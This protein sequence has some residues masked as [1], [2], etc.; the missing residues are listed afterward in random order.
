MTRAKPQVNHGPQSRQYENYRL[1]VQLV[2][3]VVAIAASLSGI[4]IF[5]FTAGPAAI[6]Q[7]PATYVPVLAVPGVLFYALFRVL[8]GRPTSW[9]DMNDIAQQ[10][11]IA[12]AVG[13]FKELLTLLAAFLVL[14]YAG[15]FAF[16][17]FI[18]GSIVRVATTV[19]IVPAGLLALVFMVVVFCVWKYGAPIMQA[20]RYWISGGGAMKYIDTHPHVFQ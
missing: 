11:R 18:A 1:L 7:Y 19:G 12:P 17:G 13:K 6:A 15:V 2:A 14:I 5:I 4:T 9:K 20:L 8:S 3:L 16:W 10:A